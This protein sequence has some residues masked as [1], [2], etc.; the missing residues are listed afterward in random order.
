MHLLAVSWYNTISTSSISSRSFACKDAKKEEAK[1]T[2][3]LVQKVVQQ[4]GLL[5]SIA[6]DCDCYLYAFQFGQR[7]AAQIARTI[8]RRATV[9]AG[10]LHLLQ[11][12]GERLHVRQRFIALLFGNGRLKKEG[13]GGGRMKKGYI[14]SAAKC[15]E[16]HEIFT[17]ENKEHIRGSLLLIANSQ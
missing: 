4:D 14:N 9:V 8:V 3:V 7:H 11:L 16:P 6:T 15:H 12:F 5:R 13:R 2:G 1:R 10:H 17:N